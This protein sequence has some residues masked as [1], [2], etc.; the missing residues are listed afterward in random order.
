M[1]KNEAIF[2]FLC[3]LIFFFILSH[4]FFRLIIDT[5]IVPVI[6]FRPVLAA[7]TAAFFVSF[8]YKYVDSK[9]NFEQ[10]GGKLFKDFKITSKK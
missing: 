9:Y 5:L 7:I 4:I 3:T 8:G 2:V 1:K 6:G 10:K